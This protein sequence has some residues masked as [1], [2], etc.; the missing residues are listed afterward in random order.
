MTNFFCVPA[1][2]YKPSRTRIETDICIQISGSTC[3]IGTGYKR[4]DYDVLFKDRVGPRY[5]LTF[6]FGEIGFL[7]RISSQLYLY[8]QC[9]KLLSKSHKHISIIHSFIKNN[10]NNNL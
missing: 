8:K 5:K 10:N 9:S 4:L 7:D 2:L 6:V 3:Q 1:Q